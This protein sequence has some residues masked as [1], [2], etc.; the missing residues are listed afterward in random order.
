MDIPVHVATAACLCSVTLYADSRI[1]KYSLSTRRSVGLG[2]VCFALG[3]FFHLMLDAVPHYDIVYK[4]LQF[5]SLPH[6]LGGM[7][8]IFKVA[9]LTLPVILLFLY[10][11]SDHWLIALVAVLGGIYPD[12]EKALYLNLPYPRELVLFKFHSLAYSSDGWESE[13]KFFLVVVE[14]CVLLISL[15]GLYWSASRR[16]QLCREAPHVKPY[17]KYLQAGL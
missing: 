16:K 14:V 3:A 5:S 6:Y 1:R 15:A 12:I 9:A 10:L 11:T 17:S 8:A 2:S 4:I 13:H 7:L